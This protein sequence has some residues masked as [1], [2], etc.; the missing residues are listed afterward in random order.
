MIDA[1]KEKLL[2]KGMELLQSPAV[3]K[4][5][6]SE[7]VGTILEKAM[8]FPIK[9]SD[10]FRSHKERLSSLLE[11]ATQQDLDDLKRAVTR[12]ES[13]LKDLM[14]IDLLQDGLERLGEVNQFFHQIVDPPDGLDG[15]AGKDVSKLVIVMLFGQELREGGNRGK[16]VLD[17]VG[18]FGDDPSKR[19]EPLRGRFLVLD[20]SHLCDVLDDLEN[21]SAAVSVQERNSPDLPEVISMGVGSAIGVP[22]LGDNLFDGADWRELIQTEDLMALFPFHV[23][24][25][26]PTGPVGELDHMIRVLDQ[27]RIRK[28]VRKALQILPCAFQGLFRGFLQGGISRNDVNANRLRFFS[29]ATKLDLDTDVVAALPHEFIFGGAN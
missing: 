7:Q 22:S 8:T 28:T 20:I 29:E 15:R 4:L 3:A 13:L 5:M 23:S 6:E 16:G 24:K 9:M 1:V 26:G 19:S 25:P 10:K 27:H 2:A 18:H 12:M 14:K 11:L 21:R 17:L